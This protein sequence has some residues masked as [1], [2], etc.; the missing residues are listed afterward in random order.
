VGST[1]AEFRKVIAGEA[2]R[3]RRLVDERGLRTVQ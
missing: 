2:L 1:P 3:W